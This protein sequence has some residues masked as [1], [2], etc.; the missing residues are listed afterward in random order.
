MI[1][2]AF[3]FESRDGWNSRLDCPDILDY[4]DNLRVD[5]TSK[6]QIFCVEFIVLDYPDMLSDHDILDDTSK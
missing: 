6:H 4:S 1:L 5:G 2:K 3:E